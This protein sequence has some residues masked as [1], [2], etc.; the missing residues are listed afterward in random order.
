MTFKNAFFAAAMVLVFPLAASAQS[1][2]SKYCSA[3]SASYEKYAQDN[4]GK[5]HNSPPADVGDA[6]GKCNSDPSSAIPVLEKAL[7]AAKIPLPSK[8]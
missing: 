4:G 8:S 6:M 1:A 2:D 3:L 7:N 5:T